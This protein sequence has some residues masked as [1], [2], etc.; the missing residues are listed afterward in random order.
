MAYYTNAPL[1]IESA[2]NAGIYT[3]AINTGPL[4]KET[5][6]KAGAD[7]VVDTTEQLQKFLHNIIPTDR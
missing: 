2:V 5:L 3:I 7:K 4:E 6:K 1:G